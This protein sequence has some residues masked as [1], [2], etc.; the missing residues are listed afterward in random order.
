MITR[1]E[2][3]KG[4]DKLF[5]KM[6]SIGNTGVGK[7]H[8][9]ATFKKCYFLITGPGEEDT[10]RSKPELIKNIVGID[11]FI[12]NSPQDT[13]RVFQDL[14][15]ATTEA[16][17]LAKEGK[18]ETLVLDNMTY[19]VENRWLYI[20]EYEKEISSS[21]ALNTQAMYGK[22]A[23]WC[24]QFTLMKLLTF[25]GHVIVNCHEQLETDEALMKKPDKTT[26]VLPSILGGF[27]DKIGGMFSL[28]GYLSKIK[29]D[30]K[31][32]FYI[33]TNKGNQRNGKCRYNLPEVIEDVS[34]TKII[35]NIN[36]ALAV[37]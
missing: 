8:F 35:D 6:L 11:R 29:K 2:M 34:Y 12:P 30:G 23:R 27:R 36:K 18:I 7:T 21:G 32:R 25:P 1:E 4:Q 9:A 10:F 31:Y 5:I 20:N 17:K 13:K 24:Y 16:S 19:L 3:L 15:R 22:L 28:V 33:R 26:P 14:A 37:K